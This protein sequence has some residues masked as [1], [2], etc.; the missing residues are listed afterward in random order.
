VSLHLALGSICESRGV[1]YAT[2]F[3]GGW[4]GKPL[5]QNAIW[6]TTVDR[7]LGV[8]IMKA[9]QD[10]GLSSL[11]FSHRDSEGRPSRKPEGLS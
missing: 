3:N 8:S 2:G 6:E 9:R 5:E 1:E 7:S 4:I 10:I 11:R